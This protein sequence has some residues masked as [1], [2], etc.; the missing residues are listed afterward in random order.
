MAAAVLTRRLCRLSCKQLLKV[1]KYFS[2]CKIVVLNANLTDFAPANS[3][4]MQVAPLE[5][6]S[7]LIIS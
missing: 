7:L 5:T 1:I 2:I 4:D 6:G 3:S